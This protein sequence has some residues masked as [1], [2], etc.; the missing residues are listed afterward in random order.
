M[1]FG[2]VNCQ[3]LFLGIA[4]PPEAFTICRRDRYSLIAASF[5][6]AVLRNQGFCPQL[7]LSFGVQ[8]VFKPYRNHTGGR[9][10]PANG[11]AHRDS[12]PVR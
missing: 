2:L 12:C 4:P 5:R 11:K 9:R 6:E 7:H 1:G 3:L 8:A 10:S